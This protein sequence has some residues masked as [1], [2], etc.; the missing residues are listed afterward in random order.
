MS[1][2]PYAP[3]QQVSDDLTLATDVEGL[4]APSVWRRWLAA[5][6]DGLITGVLQYL[7]ALLLIGIG[8]ENEWWATLINLVFM[9]GVP[10]AYYGL[11]ESSSLQGTLGKAALGLRVVDRNGQ[12]LTGKKAAIRGVVRGLVMNIF[13]LLAIVILFDKQGRGLWDMVAGSRV[14]ERRYLELLDV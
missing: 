7:P 3:P 4:P 13:G 11:L 6:I 9:F 10:M 8:F 2:N 1:D 14:A 5:M 12:R